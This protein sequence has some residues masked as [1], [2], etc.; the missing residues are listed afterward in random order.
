MQ[1]FL[2]G[3]YLLLHQTLTS[4]FSSLDLFQLQL[5]ALTCQHIRKHQIITSPL[6][7]SQEFPTKYIHTGMIVMMAD[8][9]CWE[10]SQ[11]PSLLLQC[12]APKYV[13]GVSSDS[14]GMW[15]FNQLTSQNSNQNLKLHERVKKS[16]GERMRKGKTLW[17]SQVLKNDR[18]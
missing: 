8:L 18:D 9:E 16:K 11:Q 14:I 6:Q 10:F 2:I 3:N 4:S 17:N 1:N 12:I 7:I 15:Q 13:E 5:L